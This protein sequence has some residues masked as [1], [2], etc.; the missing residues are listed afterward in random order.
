[1]E[2]ASGGELFDRICTAGRFSEHEAKYFFQQLISGVSFCHAMQICHRDL[3]LENTLLRWHT[4]LKTL[5]VAFLRSPEE[6]VWLPS[7]LDCLSKAIYIGHVLDEIKTKVQGLLAELTTVEEEITLLERKVDELKLNI[8]REKQQTQL[9]NGEQLLELQ[10]QWSREKHKH[11]L[12]REAERMVLKSFG[13]PTRLQSY[14]DYRNNRT[15]REM[16]Q[17]LRSSKDIRSM[18]FT[19]SSGYITESSRYPE[20]SHLEE[21]FSNEKPNVLSEELIKCLIGIYIKLNQ[22]FLG[23]E[24][25]AIIPKP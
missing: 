19:I 7:T 8:Y 16:R 11:L 9:C 24:G 25:S 4:C 6:E 3:K 2:Y 20:N 15:S 21:E 10:P 14:N 1:M 13:S 17:F 5:K 12:G 23:S 18:S 22:D